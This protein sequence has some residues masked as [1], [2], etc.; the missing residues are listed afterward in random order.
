MPLTLNELKEKLTDVDEVTL[1]EKLE[2]YSD[3]IVERFTDKIE[4]KFDQLVEEFEIEE[5]DE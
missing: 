4:E 3:D 5:Y 1:V 2:I